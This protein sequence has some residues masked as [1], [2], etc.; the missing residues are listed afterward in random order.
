MVDLFK[1]MY[2][3]NCRLKKCDLFIS[4]VHNKLNFVFSYLSDK[5]RKL[6]HPI[7]W[8]TKIVPFLSKE[9]K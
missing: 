4:N 2:Y 9:F 1:C 6:P 5:V 3:M 8:P 7:G